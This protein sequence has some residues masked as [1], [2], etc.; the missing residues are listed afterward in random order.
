MEG[1][2][3]QSVVIEVAMIVAEAVE[4]IPADTAIVVVTVAAVVLFGGMC[5]FCCTANH[6]ISHV[7]QSNRLE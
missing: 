3:Y 5:A 2:C 6:T 7:G 1:S 4:N